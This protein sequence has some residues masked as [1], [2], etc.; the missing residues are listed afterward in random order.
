MP[1]C[2]KNT[3]NT[4]KMALV[5]VGRE[6]VS[7]TKVWHA[8]FEFLCGSSG[9]GVDRVVKY[10]IQICCVHGAK[11]LF[12][13]LSN[14]QQILSPLISS[15]SWTSNQESTL[16]VNPSSIEI[17][18]ATATCYMSSANFDTDVFSVALQS[19]T[20]SSTD[21][22]FGPVRTPQKAQKSCSRGMFLW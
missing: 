3:L 2:V 22:R 8:R 13:F 21:D 16:F 14:H 1:Y 9:S 19:S 20:S 15:L 6:S 10:K 11:F 12:T 5:W 7:V 17:E 18:S 4:A